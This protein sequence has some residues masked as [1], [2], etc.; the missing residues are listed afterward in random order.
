MLESVT[1]SQR[2]CGINMLKVIYIHPTTSHRMCLWK[3]LMLT[4]FGK[5]NEFGIIKIF[6]PNLQ[7]EFVAI[8]KKNLF[9]CLLGRNIVKYTENLFIFNIEW[10]HKS[11]HKCKRFFFVLA[12]LWLGYLKRKLCT[13]GIYK[14]TG[15]K[16]LINCMIYRSIHS[17]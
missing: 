7:N 16:M 15:K 4:M 17:T 11:R 3:L 1:Y 14:T 9:F 2:M 6:L 13:W 8:I 5:R 12:F 10:V